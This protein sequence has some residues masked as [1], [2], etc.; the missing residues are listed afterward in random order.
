MTANNDVTNDNNGKMAQGTHVIQQMPN[1]PPPALVPTQ[2]QMPAPMPVPM[3]VD[4]VCRLFNFFSVE[5][6][7]V[8]H[9]AE[10]LIMSYASNSQKPPPALI[11]Q[12]APQQPQPQLQQQAPPPQP[13]NHPAPSGSVV[14]LDPSKIVPIQIT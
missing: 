7:N 11:R 5:F 2:Q 9:S 10:L 6:V 12:S 14:A 1:K 8:R 4:Q 13:T 3:L